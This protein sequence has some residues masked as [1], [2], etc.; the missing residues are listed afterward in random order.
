MTVRAAAPPLPTL[1]SVEEVRN[2]SPAEAAC[3]Y[4]VRFRATVLLNDHVETGGAL[5]EVF[6]HDGHLG[7]YVGSHGP[8]LN[9]QA[10]DVVELEGHSDV[11]GFAPYITD[12]HFRKIGTAPLPPPRPT[13]IPEALD[14]YEDSQWAEFTGV[15]RSVYLTDN[16]LHFQIA[17]GRE[18]IVVE[19]ASQGREAQVNTTFVDALV[20]VRGVVCPVFNSR[21]QLLG[22]S[23]YSP[24][25]SF[26][27]TITAPPADPF[28]VP[29][30]SYE[31]LLQYSPGRKNE[32]R[33]KVRGTVSFCLPGKDVFL[34]NGSQGLLLKSIQ[35]TPLKPGD[36]VEA[37]GFPTAGVYKAI[38]EDGCFRR[39]GTSAAPLQVHAIDAATALTGEYDAT[40]VRMG[41]YLM[42]QF[43]TS[44]EEVL[45]LKDGTHLFTARLPQG[46]HSSL[47]RREGS[48]LDVTGI[49]VATGTLHAES[50]EWR[51]EA[52]QLLVAS[53][54]DVVIR[55]MPSLWTR[56]RLF[57]A[58]GIV[59]LVLALSLFW[60]NTL[61]RQVK[62]QTALIQ[63]QWR[64]E[65]TLEER[66][67][68]ARELHDTLAQSFAGSAFALE[69]VASRLKLE[70]HPI[71][72]H[73]DM[74]LQAVR[75][76]LTEARRS[77]M[78]LRA[79]PLETRDLNAAIREAA[80]TLVEG[81]KVRLHLRLLPLRKPLATEVETAFY[82][83]AVEAMT[84]AIR[85]GTPRNLTVEVST[86]SQAVALRI[87][88]DGTGF[89]PANV[90]LDQHYGLIGIRER[91][92]QIHGD[93]RIVSTPGKGS[94]V[95]LNLSLSAE[96][97]PPPRRK[98]I[99][100]MLMATLK[101]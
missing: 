15:V 76:G 96:Q 95:L 46:G 12:P 73:V 13:A 77:L 30:V 53:P 67:R 62:S 19:F 68:I 81:T 98:K 7:I 48:L 70:N 3:G 47:D 8:A 36:E 97:S 56:Q 101:D 39:I 71:C 34:A 99:T 78:N 93:L 29:V 69:G 94:D 58:T 10:G 41:G 80:Q 14:G 23:V 52:F 32:H 91:A 83:I 16:R 18:R 40:L 5:N 84:N 22:A 63:E 72:L 20:K 28:E 25:P 82:R 17:A 66:N 51:P 59:S 87:S 42:Q 33:V 89:D 74:A 9:L 60:A 6:V 100:Q 54:R 26:V 49:C 27:Q 1:T 24:D 50:T 45:L 57:M 86:S 21:K 85:H 31:D 75:S 11:G 43:K 55:V 44:T 38:L 65:A 61:R 4:P 88:D 90:P 37:L 64:R 2:L 79:A 92:E 35:Q